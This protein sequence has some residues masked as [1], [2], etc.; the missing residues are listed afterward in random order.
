MHVTT[1]DIIIVNL[2]GLSTSDGTKYELH[3]ANYHKRI[4][5]IAFGETVLYEGLHPW[6]KRDI[7]R[8]EPDVESLIDYLEEFYFVN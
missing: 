3:D 6:I 8:V 2:E 1:S 5:V 4:P 7:T